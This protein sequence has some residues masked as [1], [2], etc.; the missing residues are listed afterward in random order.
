MRKVIYLSLIVSAIFGGCSSS[1]S[2]KVEDSINETIDKYKGN[3]PMVV[4]DNEVGIDVE[5]DKRELLDIHNRAREEVGVK[6][7]FYSASLEKRAQEYADKL[8]LSGKFEHDPTNKT[9]DLKT[10][11]GENLYAST[12]P[13]VTFKEAALAWE[14]EKSYYHYGKIDEDGTC[15]KNK[16]CGHY[17]QMIWKYTTKVGCAKA[18]YIKGSYSGGAVIVCKYQ[19]VGNIVGNY[20]Y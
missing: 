6:N 18:R 4:E 16:K 7:I 14:G 10:S 9:N 11:V 17:T 8:A 20:P 12:D 5:G 15:D 13:N 1:D 3:Q 19:P 2:K